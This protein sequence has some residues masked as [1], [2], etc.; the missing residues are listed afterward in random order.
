MMAAVFGNSSSSKAV[1]LNGDPRKP[2]PMFLLD[3]LGE[4]R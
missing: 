2:E 1:V 4:N 3:V